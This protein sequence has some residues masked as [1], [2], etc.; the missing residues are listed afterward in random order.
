LAQTGLLAVVNQSD[1]AVVLV[2]PVAG[3]TLASVSVGVNGHEIAISPDGKTAYVP[4][5]SNVG[6]EAAGT[7]GHEIDV[8]DVKSWHKT[9][10][11]E[12]GR[13][14]R[15]HKDVFGRDGLLYCTGELAKAVE[16]VDVQKQVIVGEVP[17]G[18]IQSHIVA[19][20]PDGKRAYT[21]NV[22]AGSVSV[23][24]LEQRKLVTVIPLTKRVQRM[25]VSNDDR[26][27][28]TADY[29]QPRVAVIDTKTNALSRWVAVGGIPYAT[30]PTGDGKSLLVDVN[31]PDGNGAIELVD[32]ATWKVVK[33][34]PVKGLQRGAFLLHGGL[35]Y[36]T[37][38]PTG[39]I[40]VFDPTT[41]ALV[42]EISLRPGVDGIA[43]VTR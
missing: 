37:V 38:P 4:I 32:L 34:L 9:G 18:A 19:L 6:V 24:D 2:D 25:A 13:G 1:H 10:S 35:A 31:T 3:K 11:I 20:S 28:F 12:L 8:I 22:D 21:A 26:W 36:L 42:R 23:L 16:I 30:Q 33:S 14:L 7:A 40:E 15:P 17:T 5:Y 29:D 41:M 39:K 43:W 27:A